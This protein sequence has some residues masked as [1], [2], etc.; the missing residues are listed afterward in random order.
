MAVE[1]TIT[2]LTKEYQLLHELVELGKTEHEYAKEVLKYANGIDDVLKS[3][4][5]EIEEL[6]KRLSMYE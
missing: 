4:D 1:S 2:I 5:A 6:R 3:K